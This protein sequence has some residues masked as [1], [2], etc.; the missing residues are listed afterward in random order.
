[1]SPQRGDISFW[2]SPRGR[3][4]KR[5]PASHVRRALKLGAAVRGTAAFARGDSRCTR[6]LDGGACKLHRRTTERAR[7]PVYAFPCTHSLPCGQKK[8]PRLKLRANAHERGL[9]PGASPLV[10]FGNTQSYSRRVLYFSSAAMN[11]SR[12]PTVN[13]RFSCP[14]RRASSSVQGDGL[15]G[16]TPDTPAA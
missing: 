3:E 9:P 6:R 10:F 1:M 8:Y 12:L 2:S 5:A 15:T 13:R 14:C 7:E 4:S 11:R 16:N